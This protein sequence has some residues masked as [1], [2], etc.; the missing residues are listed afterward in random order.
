METIAKMEQ[1][2]KGYFD[3]FVPA[4]ENH[5]NYVDGCLLN[6]AVL[7]YKQ[8][9]DVYYKEFVLDYY[10]QYIEESGNIRFYYPNDYNLDSINSG[11][12][13][14]FAYKETG[15]EKY[16]K[17][18]KLLMAQI[19][20][21]PRTYT[22]NFWHK[23]CYPE[24]VWLDGLYMAQVFYAHYQ[25]VTDQDY[26]DIISQF[27]NVRKY[28][29]NPEKGLYY[30]AIDM[31][32]KQPWC[33]KENG[34]SPNFWGRA[35]GWHVMALIDTMEIIGSGETGDY[36][37]LGSIFK[38]AVDGLL[39]HQEEKTG[40]FYQVVDRK[41][42]AENYLE[43]SGSAMV[44]YAVLKG[45]RIGALPSEIYKEQGERILNSLI[46]LK[47]EEIDGILKLGDI[48][49]G[50]GLSDDRDGTVEYYLSE[51]VGYDDHKGAAPFIMAYIESQS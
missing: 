40:L 9:K 33:N 48:C 32:K 21:Q 45:C 34:L 51:A 3:R 13:L 7:L 12:G 2:I 38:E 8:R 35:C 16:D 29:Y 1:F 17:A 41:D 43:T 15:E 4:K 18:I 36:Q 22:G 37:G 50:A 24:Q 6:A 26:S 49:R 14:F 30:H 46:Q 23:K 25:E 20:N 27:K 28:L 47:I 10:K 42:V 19:K 39:Q 31:A 44:A 5:W 11:N